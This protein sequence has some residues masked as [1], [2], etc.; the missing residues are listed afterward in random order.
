MRGGI[1]EAKMSKMKRFLMILAALGAA[2]QELLLMFVE[3]R[4]GGCRHEGCDFGCNYRRE[5]HIGS[6]IHGPYN[7]VPQ[8]F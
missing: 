1:E 4:E 3:I 8:L 2:A 7:R 5:R 6:V